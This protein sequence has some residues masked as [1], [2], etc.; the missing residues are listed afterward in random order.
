MDSRQRAKLDQGMA[1]IAHGL[2]DV[3]AVMQAVA[4]QPYPDIQLAMAVKNFKFGV[5]TL[6]MSEQQLRSMII[7]LDAAVAAAARAEQVKQTMPRG[8]S[9][10]MTYGGGKLSPGITR[11]GKNK[12]GER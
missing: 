12:E 4:G 9:G 2:A 8:S 3:M 1:T 10:G 6:Q 11:V 5:Q 7:R